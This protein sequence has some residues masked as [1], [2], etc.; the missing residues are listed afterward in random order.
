MA[1]IRTKSVK[2]LLSS[3]DLK[4]DGVSGVGMELNCNRI[5]SLGHGLNILPRGQPGLID[6]MIGGLLQAFFGRSSFGL[7]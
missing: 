7:L 1:R 4:I 5:R 3:L 2:C 6:Q